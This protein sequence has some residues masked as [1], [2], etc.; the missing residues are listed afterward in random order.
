MVG[1]ALK[2]KR[3][4]NDATVKMKTEDLGNVELYVDLRELLKGSLNVVQ[5]NG[6]WARQT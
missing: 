1:T 3:R 2:L 5:I 6:A 4:M